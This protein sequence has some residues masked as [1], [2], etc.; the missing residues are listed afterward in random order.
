V[1][2]LR[3]YLVQATYDWLVD[4]EFTP[5]L[6]L[7]G[8]D[9]DVDVPNEYIDDGRIILNV[10]PEAVRDLII[11]SGFIAFS[12]SFSGEPLEVY[13]PMHAILA[14]YSKESGQG[15]YAREDDL[16]MWVNEGETE[17]ELDP[18]DEEE[19]AAAQPSR[20][21]KETLKAA[22]KVGLRVVK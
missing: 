4:H 18:V 14:L 21:R 16:G 7:D 20:S 6:M 2:R 10:G 3:A 19:E 1:A 22:K 15:V 8:Q 12:A 11:D 9:P 13:A 17:E 5:Y